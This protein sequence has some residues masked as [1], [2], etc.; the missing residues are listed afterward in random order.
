MA[1]KDEVYWIERDKIA[2]AKLN[3]TATSISNEYTGPDGS[4][5]VTMFTIKTDDTFADKAAG[6]TGETG[7]DESPNIPTEF[8][9]AIAFRAIQLGYEANPETMQL[10]GYWDVKFK[11]AILEAKR[12]ANTGRDGAAP[13]IK[14]AEY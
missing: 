14:P 5:T 2:I 1:Y 9:D 12:Y 6:D 11:E 4:V 8:H 10:A 3:R 13:K 7:M